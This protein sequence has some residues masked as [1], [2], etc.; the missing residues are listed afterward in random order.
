MKYIKQTTILLI[1]ILAISGCSI[2]GNKYKPD[3]S[4]RAELS[5]SNLKSIN[6]ERYTSIN[7]NEKI[8][9]RAQNMTSPYG[10]SFSKYLEISL[11]E[12]LKLSSIYDKNSAIKISTVL[13]KNDV[14]ISGFSIGEANLSAKFIVTEDD[15]KIYEK[16]HTIKYVWDS[17][18]LGQIAIENALINYPLAVQK[19][20]NKFFM[21]KEFINSVKKQ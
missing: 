10:G 18:F 15:Q 19:L 16:I 1:L 14:D 9:L 21:D 17:S 12:Q 2:K 4:L 8:S 7:T 6:V 3:Y 13:L 11:E 20:I 5:D